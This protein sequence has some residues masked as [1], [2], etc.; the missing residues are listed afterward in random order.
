[1]NVKKGE[2][3]NVILLL[4]IAAFKGWAQ[5]F[6]PQFASVTFAFL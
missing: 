6:Y 5:F 3:G 4:G 2:P 1:M